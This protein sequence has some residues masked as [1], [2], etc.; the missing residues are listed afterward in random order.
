MKDAKDQK[1]VVL[2]SLQ[3]SD[4]NLILNGI[5][6]ASIFRKELCLLYNYSKKEI[7]NLE[8]LELKL[9]QYTLPI[10]NEI[11]GLKVTTLLISEKLTFL[12]EKLADDYE[13]IIMIANASA[14]KKY[15]NAVTESPIPFLFINEKNGNI[16]TFKKLILPIDFRSENSDTALWSSYFGRFNR[17]GIVVVAAND[18]NKDDQQLVNKNVFLSKKLFV[19][20]KLEHRIFKGEK[21]SFRNAFEALNLAQTSQSDLLIILGSS[22][23]TPLDRIIGLPERKII[24]NAGELPVLIVNPRRDNYILCD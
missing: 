21:S 1:V 24:E 20:F 8:N 15:T 19:K 22:S 10:T 23:I 4:K 2:L 17:A 14:Y 18:K 3:E 7:S 11:P 9:T 12:P 5:R 6:I 13:A 16:S